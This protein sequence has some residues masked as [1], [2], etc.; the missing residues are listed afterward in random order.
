MPPEAVPHR[1]REAAA[2]F[3]YNLLAPLFGL[4]LALDEPPRYAAARCGVRNLTKRS[5]S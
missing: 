4:H 2:Q 3:Q 5:W 1:L